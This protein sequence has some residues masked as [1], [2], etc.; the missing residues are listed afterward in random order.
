MKI[1]GLPQVV[2]QDDGVVDLFLCHTGANKHRVRQ[3]AERLEGE[4]IGDR[5]LRVFFDE[6]DIAPGEN[7]LSRIEEGLDG[8]RFVAVA[9]S[10]AL[11]LASWPTLEWQSQV[12]DDPTG[13]R[14]RIIPLV[15]EKFDPETREPLE[16]PLP[17]RLL[18][19]LDFS[20]P[21]KLEHEYELLVARVRGQ[22]PGRGRASPREQFSG[23]SLS[24]GPE[25]A[26]VSEEIVLSNLFPAQPPST[27][28][29]DVCSATLGEVR[30][31]LVGPF[32]I[33]FVHHENRIYS[34][35]P[36]DQENSPFRRFLKGVDP[37][38]EKTAQL[39]NAED[40]RRLVVWLCN[41]ALRER[42]YALKIRTPPGEYNPFFPVVLEGE[43][44]TFSWGKG[45]PLTLAKLST[46]DNPL[47]I[48][49]A[50][51]MRFIEIGTQLHL[52]VEPRYYFTTDGFNRVDAKKSARYS[53]RWGSRERNRTV[54]RRALMWPRILSGGNTEARLPT[55]GPDPVRVSTAPRFGRCNRG[56]LG[57][58]KDVQ[59]LLGAVAA[60]EVLE[61]TVELD[62]VVDE[63]R[64]GRVD[65]SLDD[66][67]QVGLE[68]DDL[69]GGQPLDHNPELP[70]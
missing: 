30:R 26:S 2:N 32:R 65:D 57:D 13:K 49:H 12:Y 11:T 66:R 45:V 23:L 24:A 33:P 8:S 36:L 47:G 34:F 28:Y 50:A 61:S 3:L 9:L 59:S 56:I 60:G 42:C 48:H 5:P 46:G 15:L 19:H 17:L 52:L 21:K 14:G 69:D 25:A 58:E 40:R 27:I 38:E 51:S 67:D 39:L 6:W 63:V 20:D 16:I 18:R 7:I 68:S 53:V 70:F 64:T 41:D 4:T 29:S 37:R 10:P 35:V 44:R 43:P 55:G 31:S 62:A 22:R 54:L 1:E